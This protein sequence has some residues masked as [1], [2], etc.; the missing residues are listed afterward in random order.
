V[1]HEEWS[2]TDVSEWV[3]AQQGMEEY[4]QVLAGASIDG[5]KLLGENSPDSAQP[6]TQSPIYLMLKSKLHPN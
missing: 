6:R 1:S 4:A 2:Q 3:K 5:K